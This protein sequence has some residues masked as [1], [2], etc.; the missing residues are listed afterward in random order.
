MSNRYAVGDRDTRPWGSWEVIGGGENYA[1]KRIVVSPG[2]RLSL[3][4]HQHREEHWIV[5]EGEGVV[6]RDADRIPV[7][8]GVAVHLP[9]GCVHRVENPGGMDLV[10]I[11]VQRGDPLDE[12]DI[13]RLE[14]DYGRAPEGAG[15]A[16]G[17]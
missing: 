14:D 15:A 13:E 12:N 9:L 16:A 1:V 8:S 5:V 10:F 2:A 11:E 6:T 17:A 4:R 3:Q 7:S